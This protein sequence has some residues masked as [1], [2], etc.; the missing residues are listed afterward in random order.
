MKVL[1]FWRGGLCGTAAM[2]YGVLV[3]DFRPEW[4]AMSMGIL[5]MAFGNGTGSGV[6]DWAPPL[7]GLSEADRERETQKVARQA[8]REARREQRRM[9]R[10][11]VRETRRVE[12]EA[13]KEERR[14]DRARRRR[15]RMP[16]SSY[17][18]FLPCL[19]ADFIPALIH[20][21]V[22]QEVIGFGETSFVS[23][24]PV[25]GQIA[26]AIDPNLTIA[27]LLVLVMTGIVILSPVFFFL[28]WKR[29]GIPEEGWEVMDDDPMAMAKLG[30][31]LSM[32]LGAMMLEVWT[33]WRRMELE[34]NQVVVF[35][36]AGALQMDSEILAV[37]AVLTFLATTVVGYWGSTKLAAFLDEKK[38]RVFANPYVPPFQ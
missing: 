31:P 24:V 5:G 23:G 10:E 37:T 17:L 32:Y 20:A 4:V 34:A 3:G 8:E 15:M 13:L 25:L 21:R 38:A 12:R 9:E 14:R 11:A 16:L 27:G 29:L 7:G 30:L 19:V 22:Y 28:A 36:A 26:N 1:S 33:I 2:G 35:K 6:G 18:V